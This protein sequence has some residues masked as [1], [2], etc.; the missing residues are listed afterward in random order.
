MD[1]SYVP[2]VKIET[3]DNA[4]GTLTVSVSGD[5]DLSNVGTLKAALASVTTAPPDRLVFE[6]SR[7][8]FIDSAAIAV[9]LD[10]TELAPVHIQNP[11]PSVRR[12]I[13]LTG[14]TAVLSIDS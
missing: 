5:L 9:L 10:T 12:V 13:E 7:V 11:S 2:E 8:R 1:E 4:S 3:S 14:L 6:M